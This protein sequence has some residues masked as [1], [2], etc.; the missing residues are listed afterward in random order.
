[1][2]VWRN[3]LEASGLMVA[4]F[5]T[6]TPTGRDADYRSDPILRRDA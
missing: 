3:R 5:R 4:A 2:S 1:V 6:G